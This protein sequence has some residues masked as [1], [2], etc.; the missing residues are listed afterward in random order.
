[1]MRW[2]GMGWGGNFSTALGVVG[3][4]VQP[5]DP[6]DHRVLGRVTPHPDEL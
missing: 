6:E 3:V 5:P 2:V 1:M 4:W